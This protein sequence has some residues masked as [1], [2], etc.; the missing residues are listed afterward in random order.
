MLLYVFLLLCELSAVCDRYTLKRLVILTR[1]NILAFID[2]PVIVDDTG[3]DCVFQ[4][5]LAA[6]LE[7]D[8]N[9]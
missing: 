5:K 1:F 8:Q 4:V 3:A 9:L 6:V 7:R 2:Q